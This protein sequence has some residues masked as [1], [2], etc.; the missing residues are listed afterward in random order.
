MRSAR[1]R[2]RAVTAALVAVTGGA[3]LT[4]PALAVSGDAATT[5]NFTAKITADGRACS[6]ALVAPAWVLT[7]PS[8]FPENPDGGAP[9]KATTVVV[10]RVNLGSTAGITAHASKL[11]PDAGHTVML[12]KLDKA[13]TGITPVPLSTTAPAA[14]DPVRL[15]GFGRT[16]DEWIPNVLHTSAFTVGT[17]DAAQLVLH[18]DTA[19]ACKG[20]A[21][22]P[23]FREAGGLATLVGVTTSSLQHGCMGIEQPQQGTTEIRTDTLAAWIGQQTAPAQVQCT[24]ATVWSERAGGGMWHYVHND[25]ANGTANWVNPTAAVGSGWLGRMLAAPDGI[26]WDIHKN[27]GAADTFADGVIRRFAWN[28]TKWTGGGQVGG[29]WAPYLTARTPTGSPWTRRA[30]SS[31]STPRASCGCSSGTPPPTTGSTAP[32]CRWAPT[33]S[34]TTRSPRPATACCTPVPRPAPCSG[35]STPSPT[36]GGSRSPSRSAPVGRCSARS[37]RRARTS[38]TRAA[39]RSRPARCCAGTSGTTP[40][41][42]GRRW[43]PTAPARS[44]ATAGR[45]SSTSRPTPRRAGW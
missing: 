39:P 18:S 4:A 20:D 32:A 23:A 16:A 9:A 7:V 5:Y 11:V 12:V 36:T 19:D 14:G 35:T 10:G 2:S 17:V 33:G 3:L 27:T 28:G 37:S 25:A 42:P 8:C 21:G 24:P 38:C 41:T 13:A 29:G 40:P 1:I 43:R 34:C 22:A 45:P 26:V 31:P 15:A 6:G 44:S 30:G